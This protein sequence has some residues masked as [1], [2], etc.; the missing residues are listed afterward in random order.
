MDRGLG[1]FAGLNVL[2]K[3]AWLSSYSHRVTRSMNLEFLKRIHRCWVDNRLLSDT[4]NPHI[5]YTVR[6]S[7]EFA[8]QA[9]FLEQVMSRDVNGGAQTACLTLRSGLGAGDSHDFDRLGCG[10]P[11][12]F[13]DRSARRL[14]R[15]GGTRLRTRC[16]SARSSTSH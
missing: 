9:S 15:G 11:L 2:P 3:A 7:V 5:S 16:S 4:A 8:S 10:S 6:K 12:Y 14:A 1:L 13:F